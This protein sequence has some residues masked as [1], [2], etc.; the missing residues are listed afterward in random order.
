MVDPVGTGYS[1]ATGT[2]RTWDFYSVKKDAASI[3]QFIKLYLEETGRPRS[4]I[5]LLGQSYGTIRLPVVIT[6]LRAIRLPVAGGVLIGSA[7][8]G[9]TVWTK[10]GHIEP[11]YL[12]FPNF[13]AV[14]WFH[15]RVPG[16][17]ESFESHYHA[18]GEFALNELLT[19]L[20]A[21]P[22]LLRER[23]E[24]VATQA[25]RFTGISPTVWSECRLR[26]SERQFAELLLNDSRVKLRADDARQK[27][28]AQAKTPESFPEV[29]TYVDRYY[30]EEFSIVRAPLYRWLAPGIYS[31]HDTAGSHPWDMTDHDA[32]ADVDGLMV[33]G[34]PNYLVDVAEAMRANPRMRI[35]QHSGL[36]DLVCPSFQA[37]W[38]LENIDLPDSL[39]GNFQMF[40]YLSGHSVY[41][42]APSEFKKFLR[43]IASLYV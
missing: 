37:N 21:W 27:V 17:R 39:R 2:H 6:C 42:D 16:R 22:N 31:T 12:K 4:P 8:D 10:P 11:Y 32:F 7:A 26:M 20:V 18:A 30:R 15:G 19:A 43:N 41:S 1:V 35:Q 28:P 36:Y 38:G 3:A 24:A 13:A 25:Y 5:Y 29:P 23:R 33:P 14:A 40:D 9:N 34:F